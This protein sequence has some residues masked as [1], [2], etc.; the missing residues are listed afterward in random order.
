MS[1]KEA[2]SI[3]ETP[4]R[5]PRGHPVPSPPGD[6]EVGE[7][8]ERQREEV[9]LEVVLG[10]DP[11]PVT[12]EP[13]GPIRREPPG[14]GPTDTGQSSRNRWLVGVSLTLVGAGMGALL[15]GALPGTVG[16]SIA[17]WSLRTDAIGLALILLGLWPLLHS[18][19]AK[20]KNNP[21]WRI[22]LALSKEKGRLTR[23]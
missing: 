7:Y 1:H 9:A 21:R 14:D 19:V 4:K 5:Q 3:M 23:S 8:E 15:T 18:G 20:V 22:R 13:I 12:Y 10:A 6:S 2:E 17:G 16:I 11:F